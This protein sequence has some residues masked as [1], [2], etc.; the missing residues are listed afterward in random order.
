LTL[1]AAGLVAYLMLFELVRPF[2]VV[3]WCGLAV[4][5]GAWSFRDAYGRWAH[6]AAAGVLLFAAITAILAEIVPLDRLAVQPSVAST[7]TWFALHSIVAVGA[8]AATLALAARFLP[9]ERTV[10]TG[11][12]FVAA[13]GLVYLAS[14]LV[15]DFFQGRVG[16]ATALEELQ[17][18]GQVAV[19]ILW[20]L[21]GMGVFLAGVLG[22]R[23]IVREA[24]LALLALA[25]A[26]VFVFDLSYLDVSYRVIS[27]MGLGLLLL[28]GAYAYQSLRPRRPDAPDENAPAG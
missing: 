21:I 19:S 9:L 6:V 15:V 26:K 10:R 16:G 28:G 8:T 12:A 18:Q 3:A 7:G 20:G 5:L 24:G 22:W 27:L 25:T 4:G 23:A 2:Q 13:T 17:K 14:A 1:L 11:L